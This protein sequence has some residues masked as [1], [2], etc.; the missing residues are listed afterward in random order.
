MDGNRALI[1]A[2]SR[3]AEEDGGDFARSRR[4]SIIIQAIADKGKTLGIFNNINNINSYLNI[5]GDNVTT[6]ITLK[7]MISFYNQS[8]DFDPKTGFLRVIWSADDQDVLCSGP[9]A[10]RGYNIVY[11]GSGAIPGTNSQSASRKE[12]VNQVQ[13]LLATAQAGELKASQTAILGNQSNETVKARNAF[14]KLGFDSLVFS[15]SYA[16]ITAASKTSAEKT[17]VYI[18]DE[19]LRNMF[20][21]MDPKPGVNFTVEEKLPAEKVLPDNAKA[22]KIIV[23]VESL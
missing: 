13:N 8:K 5:L 20:N 6:S 7:E 22:A 10:G 2:R 15:N 17:T 16:G 14:A 23:W 4:Q 9:S 11:C 3:M 12:A 18:A 21:A 19:S 1:Y